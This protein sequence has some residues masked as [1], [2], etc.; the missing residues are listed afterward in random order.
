MPLFKISLN[1]LKR[2]K[3]VIEKACAKVITS[4]DNPEQPSSADHTSC[5]ILFTCKCGMYRGCVEEGEITEPCPG[6][7]R[8]YKGIYNK[9]LFTVEA[10]EVQDNGRC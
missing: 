4:F 5:S 3:K 2:I 8:R 10:V 1:A 6:C 9:R 7:K